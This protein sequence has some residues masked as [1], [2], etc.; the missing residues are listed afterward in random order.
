MLFARTIDLNG[1]KPVRV[2]AIIWIYEHSSVFPL[3]LFY[4][5]AVKSYYS[6]VGILNE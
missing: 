5:T 1:I 6:L 2:A 4:K 3:K